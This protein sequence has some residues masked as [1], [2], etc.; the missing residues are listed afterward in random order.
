MT[1]ETLKMKAQ[2]DFR[3]IAGQ[4]DG[5]PQPGAVF[6]PYDPTSMTLLEALNSIPSG[7]FV[8]VKGWASSLADLYVDVNGGVYFDSVFGGD[9]GSIERS[10][11]R[12]TL[13]SSA[14]QSNKKIIFSYFEETPIN[15][16]VV[17]GNYSNLLDGVEWP[18]RP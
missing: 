2:S 6:N 1:D 5:I 17:A 3:M 10:H 16:G 13:E 18:T 4:G 12:G 14:A 7:G 9:L 8:T 11:I 15:I